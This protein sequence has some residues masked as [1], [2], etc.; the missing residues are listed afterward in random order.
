MHK[1]TR[2]LRQVLSFTSFLFPF[3]TFAQKSTISGYIVDDANGESLIS[4]NV[5]EER[6]SSGAITN[7]YG[8]FSLTVDNGPVSLAFS[9]IGYQSSTFSFD[10]QGDTSLTVSL[11]SDLTLETVEVVAEKY[12]RIE[13]NTQMSQISVPIE[14]IKY[15]PTLLG[16]KDVLKTLQLLPGVQAGGEGQTGLYVR[17]GSPDQNLIL[18]DGVPIYNVSHVLG[19]FS[20]FNP[21]AIKNVTLT[22]GGFP[23]R[24]GGRLS[25]ILEINMKEGNMRE[26]HGEGSVGLISSKLT[27]QGPIVKDKTSFLISGRR[28]YADLIARPIIKSQSVEGEEVD[29]SLYFFDL[30]AKIQHKINDKH[31]IFLS[32]YAGSD[33]FKF[34]YSDVSENERSESTGGLDWGNL[35]SALRWNY[36]ITPKLFANT[37]LTYSKYRID[38]IAGYST[39]SEFIEDESFSAKYFSGIEDLG[40]KIDFDFIPN[41]NHY[42]RFGVSATHHTYS[43]GALSYAQAYEEVDFDT[44]IGSNEVGSREY[45]IY[46]EDDFAIGDLKVNAGLHLSAFDVDGEFYS[47]LQPR[48]GARYLV[49]D[50][51][52]LKASFSTMAQY[53]NLLTSESLSLPTDLWVPSTA[54]IRPQRS[55]QAAIGAARTIGDDYE[56][57]LEAYYKEMDDV[58]SFKEGASFLFGLENDW[59]DKVTQGD[60]ETYGAELF[61][62]KK[63]GRFSGWFGYTLAWNYRQ[64]DE[65]NSGRRYPFRYD[66]RHDISIVGSY[67]WTD[68]IRISGTWVYGTGNAV[69][70]PEFVYEGAGVRGWNPE[71]ESG[72]RKNEFRMTSYHRLDLGI[73]FIKQKKWGE[74][75][76][77]V[78]VYNL[79]NHRNPYFLD[80][81]NEAIIEDGQYVGSRRVFR[82]FSILPIIPS[83]SY[84]FKF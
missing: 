53:I 38:I 25:S 20:V 18:L 36:Q 76:W 28:T 14:Q 5:Y 50:R 69:T 78:G 54:R 58:I 47:S 45:G 46:V 56:I 13:Q 44:L 67:K 66:R 37:T 75:T 23:A 72:G 74:R 15:T 10:L 24:Y 62:Q 21:D 70:I 79:Y 2:V 30:N 65:I 7:T 22:K 49:N 39:Q 57:S 51:W 82:E 55:W 77:S 83:V 4:A 9:Y 73:D 11:T 68:K 71:I 8:F 42:V 41:P 59:Q 34:K 63:K 52:S 27:L 29:P 1:H 84:S 43:P 60:G 48:L 3:L 31:R 81:T 61:L 35:I 19:I 26:F 6:S 64:F 17:G 40:A 33:L 32:G 12:E 80:D 16:E